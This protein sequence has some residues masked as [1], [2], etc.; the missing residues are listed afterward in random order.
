M[1]RPSVPSLIALLVALLGGASPT[2]AAEPSRGYSIPLVDLAGEAERQVV[3]DREPGR[4]LGHPTTVLLE[5]GRTILCVYPQGHGR[6]AIVM[7]RSA[8]GGRTWSE[9]LPV[10][11]SWAT[12][13]EVPTIHR[14]VDAAGRK[15]L[16]LCS[17][18]NP[19][20]LAVSEDDGATWSDLA[21]LGDWGGI[22]VMGS[23]VPLRTGTGGRHGLFGDRG[24]VTGGMLVD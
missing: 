22:V 16:I 10:P 19:A 18:L 20:R 15:R 6:G 14:V 24:C 8:D 13:K 12:S 5:D 21:P 3:V 17:G 9:R 23:V 11:D 1:H 4:Y 7:K 2:T